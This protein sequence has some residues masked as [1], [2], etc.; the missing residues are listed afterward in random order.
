MIT[1]ERGPQQLVLHAGSTTIALD[2]TA[3]KA[4]LQR[5]MLFWPRKPIERSLS[6]IKQIKLNADVDP[7]SRAEMYSAMLLMREGDRWV[8]SARGKQDATQ[9]LEALQDFLGLTR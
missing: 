4:V 8:L 1:L 3:G 2:K 9:A 6:S 5:K 7:A